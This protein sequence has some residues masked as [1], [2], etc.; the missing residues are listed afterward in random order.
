MGS[1]LDPDGR[2]RKYGPDK[3]D[4]SVGGEYVTTGAI[5]EI[6]FKVDLTTLTTTPTPISDHVFFPKMRVQEVETI[7]HTAASAGT[8]IDVGLLKTDRTTAYD[9]D[10]L[11][12]AFPAAQMN[13][14]GERIIFTSNSTVPASQTGTGAVIGTT[15]TS[16]AYVT[17]NRTDATA[18][19][20]GVLYVKLKYYAA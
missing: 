20:A 9:A 4:P 19:T 14:A 1:W 3:A 17:V 16:A 10:G 12:A 2:Y 18:F 5:R 7:T 15:T 11:L 8:A 13:S 6:E